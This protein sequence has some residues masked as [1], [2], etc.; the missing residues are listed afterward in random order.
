M[1][2]GAQASG[3]YIISTLARIKALGEQGNEAVPDAREHDPEREEQFEEIVYLSQNIFGDIQKNK[4]EIL[5]VLEEDIELFP[6]D[7]KTN[8]EYLLRLLQTIMFLKS[9][10]GG[11]SDE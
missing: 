9:Q 1:H 8:G 7:A 11:K 2:N 3:E 10:K 5:R 6:A 4:D